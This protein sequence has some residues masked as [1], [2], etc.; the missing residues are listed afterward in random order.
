M[1][2]R[3]AGSNAPAPWCWMLPQLA[4][5]TCRFQEGTTVSTWRCW[6]LLTNDCSFALDSD[7]GFDFDSG[8]DCRSEPDSRSDFDS[9][10]RSGSDSDSGFDSD[11]PAGSD[12]DS[13]SSD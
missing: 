13:D 5:V 7:S 4:K 9:D 10:F 2:V 11:S 3:R 8:S 6:L 1:R 12:S